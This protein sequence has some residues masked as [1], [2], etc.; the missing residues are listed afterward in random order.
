VT[1]LPRAPSTLAKTHPHKEDLPPGKRF[2]EAH[3]PA[4]SHSSAAT[5]QPP[6]A[7]LWVYLEWLAI[8]LCAGIFAPP[9]LPA[10]FKAIQTDFPNYYLSAKLAVEGTDT[11]H[12]YDWIWFARQKDH[13]QID[14]GVVG[15][16]P[17]TTFSTLALA[18]LV[19]F[20]PLTAKRIWISFQ[21][22]LLIPIGFALRAITGQPLRRIALIIAA[23]HPLYRNFLNGQIYVVL[24]ALLIG[25]CWAHQRQ[26]NKLAGALVAIAT[27]IKLFPVIFF[28]YFLRKRNRPALISAVLTGAACAAASVAVF[29]WEV[30]RTFLQQVLPWT[31]RGD[32]DPPFSLVSG[33]ISSLL[34]CLF[35]Y[36]PQWNPHPWHTAPVLFAV[37]FAVLPLVI[38]APAILLCDERD[39]SPARIALEWSALL[40][41]TLT[42][43]PMPASYNFTLL[44][45]PMA[46]L[47]ALYLKN[48]S[49]LIW[50]AAALYI[51]IG[52]PRGWHIASASGLLVFLQMERLYLLILL[53][54]LFY[55]ALGSVAFRSPARRSLTVL[56]ACAFVLLATLQARSGI[57]HQRGLSDDYAYR[58]PDISGVP[59]SATS[60]SHGESILRIAMQPEGYRLLSS[61]TAPSANGPS[62][63]HAP[64]ELAFAST[65][66]NLLVESAGLHSTIA[67][68]TDPAFAPIP[69]A[70]SPVLSADGR[71]LAYLRLDHGQGQLFLR[72]M[73]QQSGPHP[74][75]DQRMTP[76][77]LNVEHATFLPDAS[78]IVSGLVDGVSGSRILRIRQGQLP[79]LLPLGEARYPAVSPDGHWL[80]YSRMD[81]GNWNLSLLDLDSG[82]IHTIAQAEC[83]TI[84]PAWEPDSK[85]ILYGSD[86][87]RAL[88]F[89]AISRRRVIP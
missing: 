35:V 47:A 59:L 53:A 67:S 18:P 56:I 76:P 68:R 9:T 46:V 79:E 81:R 4:P 34:H 51:G 17:I 77:S 39:H 63:Q 88:W 29:G 52:S 55:I 12:V 15:L 78:L 21:F 87:G 69:D 82:A 62:V 71:N 14:R 38:L 20:D 33:S 1:S 72:A 86:C 73:Q 36:E 70:E 13:H 49:R 48:G 31:L 2:T 58:L 75:N 6:P 37:L 11:A 45:L 65:P 83:N 60:A 41:A 74:G 26:R 32:G 85:T 57:R 80:A 84:E 5:P 19:R 3:I 28:L 10:A 23:C 30:H 44:I 8:V 24:A 16:V 25:A 40:V 7:R 61:M 64:D 54:A 66:G 42:I 89:T 27:A 22:L 50:L 43:S